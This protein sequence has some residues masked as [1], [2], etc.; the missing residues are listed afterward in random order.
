MI[1]TVVAD[2]RVAEKQVAGK[3]VA[4]NASQDGE[5]R[6]FAIVAE[7]DPPSPREC[8]EQRAEQIAR[9]AEAHVRRM[10]D[11]ESRLVN[12][13]VSPGRWSVDAENQGAVP[14]GLR[15]RV[16]LRVPVFRRDDGIPGES[17]SELR[18]I[19]ALMA[20][21]ALDLIEQVIQINRYFASAGLVASPR[22]EA[23]SRSEDQTPG[24]D[25]AGNT[26]SGGREG[27]SLR[28]RA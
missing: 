2:E 7:A 13:T 20:R 3:D 10:M 24:P 25:S 5:E 15:R 21:L 11:E 17:A 26:M 6:G 12:R 14:F 1:I 28:R 23:P 22:E 18:T 4:E 27:S 8:W 19:R 16:V 9:A